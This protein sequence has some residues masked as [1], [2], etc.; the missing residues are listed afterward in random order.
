MDKGM[1]LC[2]F[3]MR[4]GLFMENM[5]FMAYYSTKVGIFMEIQGVFMSLSIE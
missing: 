5:G 2:R 4:M 3:S 1:V